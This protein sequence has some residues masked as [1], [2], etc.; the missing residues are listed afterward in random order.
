MEAQEKAGGQSI[1]KSI[2]SGKINHQGKLFTGPGLK[3]LKNLLKNMYIR[4]E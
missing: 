1:K 4:K 2:Q 3:T